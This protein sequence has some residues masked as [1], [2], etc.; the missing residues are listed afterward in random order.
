[1]SFDGIWMRGMENRWTQFEREL[2][3][4][5]DLS[6]EQLRLAALRVQAHR[7]EVAAMN[8]PT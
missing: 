7:T 2:P 6:E 5:E 3:N 4:F 1:M 8:L